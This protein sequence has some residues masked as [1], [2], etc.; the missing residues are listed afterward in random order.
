M[1]WDPD[2]DL[3]AALAAPVVSSTT[4]PVQ[5]SPSGR[6]GRVDTTTQ[7]Q[8]PVSAPAS[9]WNPDADLAAQAQA[10]PAPAGDWHSQ[11][12]PAVAPDPDMGPV[13]K[14]VQSSPYMK[15]AKNPYFLEVANRH[16]TTV[17]GT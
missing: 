17:Y 3:A 2:S 4:G 8:V 10:A 15:D 13:D 12:V 9:T 5:V 7:A 14:L 6:M 16:R 1:A 11:V